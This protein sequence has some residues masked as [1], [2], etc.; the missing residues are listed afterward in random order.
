MTNHDIFKELGKGTMEKRATHANL[1]IEDGIL[2]SYGHHFPLALHAGDFVVVNGDRTTATTTKQRSQLVSTLLRYYRK[3]VLTIPFPCFVD[4]GINVTHYG[5]HYSRSYPELLKKL[6]IHYYPT[7]DAYQLKLKHEGKQRYFIWRKEKA[8]SWMFYEVADD[9]ADVP[10]PENYQ[11]DWVFLAPYW[12]EPVSVLPDPLF[13]YE[14][15]SPI[16]A[17]GSGGD[18]CY[19]EKLAMRIKDKTIE[20]VYV[21]GKIVDKGNSSHG[22]RFKMFRTGDCWYKVHKEHFIVCSRG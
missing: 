9:F 18:Y 16:P 21:L 11:T 7:R 22:K 20:E 4:A 19:A 17:I 13:D 12:L 2:Y 8:G 10:L 14:F 3:D 1:F 5:T 6:V 15:N